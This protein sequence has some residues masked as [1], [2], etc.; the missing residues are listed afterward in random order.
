M[1]PRSSFKRISPLRRGEVPYCKQKMTAA[2]KTIRLLP[3]CPAR[4]SIVDLLI[5]EARE[6]QIQELATKR[7]RRFL[8]KALK[9]FKISLAQF[10]DISAN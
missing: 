3:R 4:D 7:P 8:C 10:Y 6:A 5:A 2:V 9:A 1:M